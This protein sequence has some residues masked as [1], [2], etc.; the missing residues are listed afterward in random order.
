MIALENNNP[1]SDP[2]AYEN[3]S[4]PQ[5]VYVRLENDICFTTASFLI[6]TENCPPIIYDGAS[7]NG[8]GMN[9]DFII[10]N[11]VNV[12]E[13]FDLLIFSREGN[14]IYEGGNEEGLWDCKSNTGLFFVGNTVPTGTYFY[15][16][17]LND[18]QYPDPF[19]G[20]VYVN[21]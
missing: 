4:N 11:L 2:T 3:V 6:E 15:V 1:I 5:T 19:T 9:D 7:P 17:Y 18:P 14:L 20:Q 12:Y 16:L 21:Y 13:D 8:D 10:E